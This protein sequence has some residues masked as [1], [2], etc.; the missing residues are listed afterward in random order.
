MDA[1]AKAFV[2]EGLDKTEP[3]LYQK[4]IKYRKILEQPESRN[5]KTKNLLMLGGV[6]FAAIT[7]IGAL[8]I[9]KGVRNSDTHSRYPA[10]K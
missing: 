6:I 8:I 9:K 3:E 2:A 7:V 5:K 4:I 10:S 1:L